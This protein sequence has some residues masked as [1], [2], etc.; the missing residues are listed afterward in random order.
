MLLERRASWL[1]LLSQGRL[2]NVKEQKTK[3]LTATRAVTKT[4]FLATAPLDKNARGRL[5]TKRLILHPESSFVFYWNIVL[6][7][8]IVYESFAIP[9]IIFFGVQVQGYLGVFEFSI[10]IA[11]LTDIGTIH[12]VLNFNTAFFLKG[13]FISDRKTIAK[14]YIELW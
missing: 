5:F 2:D 9:F 11:F 4:A 14:K 12:S 8:L 10:T 13:A 3:T 6:I 1:N 7:L